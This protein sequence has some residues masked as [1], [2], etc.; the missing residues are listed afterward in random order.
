M[1]RL[2]LLFLSVLLLGS[3]A[4][5]GQ[6]AV[7]FQ[8]DEIRASP[9]GGRI[10]VYYP[11][12]KIPAKLPCVLIAGSG[13]NLFHGMNLVGEDR[14]EH[15][16]Y[17]AAGFVVVAYDL[18]GPLNEED[19]EQE[20]LV[21]KA[22]EAFMKSHGGIDDAKAALA[23]ASAKYP[24]IDLKRV[25]AVGHSSAA[26]LALTLAQD[27]RLH[28][29]GCVA[30][31]PVADLSQDFP[32]EMIRARDQKS[33]K[34]NQYIADNSP[35][36]NIRKLQ[37]PVFLFDARDDDSISPAEVRAYAAKLKAAGKTVDYTEVDEGGHYD[38][39]IRK[40]I[41]AGLAWLKK[42]ESA[43]MTAEGKSAD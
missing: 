26:T 13:T 17:V 36:Q 2:L 31:A 40:G 27:A 38:S 35:M 12:G 16:P 32:V 23:C 34:I 30:Y 43:E 8:K 10:W 18:S 28:L 20:E 19:F 6:P 21:L 1:P 15:L 25:Y 42:I 24:F 9:G 29:R 3:C 33:S 37:C 5:F 7:S 4:H 11:V 22:A 39:M 14:V 41:P